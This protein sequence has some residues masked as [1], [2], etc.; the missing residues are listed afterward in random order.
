MDFEIFNELEKIEN[1]MENDYQEHIIPHDEFRESALSL[2]YL[3]TNL[4]SHSRRTKSF[5]GGRKIIK[6]RNMSQKKKTSQKKKALQKASQ[7]SI[8]LVE[9]VSRFW[10]KSIIFLFFAIVMLSIKHLRINA[11]DDI[12]NCIFDNAST[13]LKI[14]DNYARHTYNCFTDPFIVRYYVSIINYC[15]FITFISIRMKELILDKKNL[16]LLLGF[17]GISYSSIA[18]IKL[19]DILPISI[20]ATNNVVTMTNELKKTMY[21]QF[22]SFVDTIHYQINYTSPTN[23]KQISDSMKKQNSKNKTLKLKNKIKK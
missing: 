22:N 8:L 19:F 7:E 3:K 12:Y 5:N 13:L 23:L 10:V 14:F 1:K 16:L 2:D 9:K 11:I 17:C 21:N 4:A 6:L 18:N 20:R 15:S